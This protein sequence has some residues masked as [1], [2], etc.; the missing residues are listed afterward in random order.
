M[1]FRQRRKNDEQCEGGYDRINSLDVK[2]EGG[3]VVA[4][5]TDE[6]TSC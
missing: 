6:V 1:S 2:I 3:V 5:A 4:L